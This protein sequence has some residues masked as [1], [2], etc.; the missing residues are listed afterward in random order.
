MIARSEDVN[1][2]F[3]K[4]NLQGLERITLSLRFGS[5]YRLM[6]PSSAFAGSPCAEGMDVAGIKGM[7]FW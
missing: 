1:I 2:D 5:E 3:A 4:A 7:A 6:Y